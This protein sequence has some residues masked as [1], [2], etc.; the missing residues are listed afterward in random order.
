MR[1]A[2]VKRSS[3]SNRLQRGL[4]A[5][6]HRPG[7]VRIHAHGITFQGK[8]ELQR[9]ASRSLYPMGWLSPSDTLNEEQL[10]SN[11]RDGT[12]I[13][14][15]CVGDSKIPVGDLRALVVMSYRG[16]PLWTRATRKRHPYTLLTR[17][18]F[19]RVGRAQPSHW[20]A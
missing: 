10:K 11:A 19:E 20:I 12:G 8:T 18:F 3:S 5:S 1:E 6:I 14:S 9:L 15:G 16:Q 17:G 7:I 13:H 4:P 2:L